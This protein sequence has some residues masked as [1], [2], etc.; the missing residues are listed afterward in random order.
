MRPC[1]C[2]CGSGIPDAIYGTRRPD[3]TPRTRPSAARFLRGHHLRVA[4]PWWNDDPGYHTIHTYLGQ[5]YPK[6]GACEECGTP[7]RTDYANIHGRGYTR[8]REDYRELCRRCHVAYDGT[9]ERLN[10]IRHPS[11][12]VPGEPPLCRCG[13][14]GVTQW[15]PKHAKF[16]RYIAGH[17]AGQ[18]RRAAA[19][20]RD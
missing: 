6:A 20:G 13:C 16:N 12:A 8:N 18:A 5:H 10:A 15:N 19:H 2:G 17:Y 7:G 1:E 4:C 9:A 14:A 3:G 11:P